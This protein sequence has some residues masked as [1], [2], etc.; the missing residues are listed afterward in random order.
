MSDPGPQKG[1]SSPGRVTAQHKAMIAELAEAMDRMPVSERLELIQ[2]FK[3]VLGGRYCLHC[4]YRHGARRCQC[5]ND[6]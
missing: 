3:E 1:P 4:G 5:Q 6:D 2:E